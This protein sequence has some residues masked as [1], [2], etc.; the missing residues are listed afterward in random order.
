MKYL[1]SA[2]FVLWFLNICLLDSMASAASAFDSDVD[3]GSDYSVGSNTIESRPG[4]EHQ[5]KV[6]ETMDSGGYTYIQIEESG[7]K[8]WVAVIQTKVK[9]GDVVAFPDIPSMFDFMSKDLNRTFDEIKFAADIRIVSASE[10]DD[11]DISSSNAKENIKLLVRMIRRLNNKNKYYSKISKL[12]ELI[13]NDI[14]NVSA[15][16]QLALSYFASGE[17]SNAILVA[18]MAIA[19]NKKAKLA[20]ITK[21]R[22][23]SNLGKYSIA[24]E[25]MNEGIVYNPQNGDMYYQ[26]GNAYVGV[27]DYN[28]AI[29]S[30]ITAIRIN[31]DDS[32]YY[33][34]LAKAYYHLQ[35]S[36]NA[37][38]NAK[39]AIKLAP[40]RHYMLSAYY[41]VLGDIYLQMAYESIYDNK[42]PNDMEVQF[43]NAIEA[44]KLAVKEEPNQP[45]AYYKLANAF[46]ISS[47]LEDALLAIRE[48][49]KLNI[50]EPYYYSVLAKIL[51]KQK[52]YSDAIK[53]QQNAIDK[54]I[55]IP[56]K[57]EYMKNQAE[58][59]LRINEK[60]QALV[61]YNKMSEID[62]EAANELLD[63]IFK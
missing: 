46:I 14:K 6:V 44:Y 11:N 35:D 63:R 8:F 59:Y 56:V 24:L 38:L 34:G 31:T 60:S 52:K 37:F 40:K 9:V 33:W 15:Y 62:K 49:I 5:G 51:N 48:A 13:R 32:E 53:A 17:D 7:N 45:H 19:I 55:N 36:E 30:Y 12:T 21:S 1:C 39:M 20:Y 18:N 27:E 26:L 3:N 41:V 50:N 23:L 58:N 16:E 43:N 57:I 25:V 47:R 28:K 22:S 29:A 54:E 42:K 10:T 2:V 61:I 4:P